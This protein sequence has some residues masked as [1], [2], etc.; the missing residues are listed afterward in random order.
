[1][2]HTYIFTFILSLTCLNL[3]AQVTDFITGL[4]TP[5]GMALNGN[6]LYVAAP[7]ANKI[8]KID[9]TATTPTATDVVT[10]LS[11]PRQLF[12]S[13]NDLYI[14]EHGASKISK[15]NITDAPLVVTDVINGLSNP[16]GVLVN[17][18]DLYI[19]EAGGEKVSKFNLAAASPTT[20][21]FITG[22]QYPT[23]FA[24]NGN[25][26]YVGDSVENNI[27]KIDLT[28]TTPTATEVVAASGPF[29]LVLYENEIYILEN[30]S[31]RVSKIDFTSATPTRT[32]VVTGLE[33]YPAGM[34][35]K[36]DIIYI[37]EIELGK[38]VSTQL[39]LSTNE[40]PF[41]ENIRLFP[42]PSSESIQLSGLT[43]EESYTIF[44]TQ[45][46]VMQSG[47]VSNQEHIGIKTLSKGLYFLK[48]DSGRAFRF[49]R[50]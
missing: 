12:F 14:T 35:I 22:L 19:V 28:A 41:A 44:N 49:V 11:A 7:D 38:I 4:T 26:L 45:G 42:N 1:M 27:I 8:I 10:G 39:P 25:D 17:G 24:L 13:G 34:V 15:I 40:N 20:T 6:D 16:Q 33:D 2:K 36:D 5:Q 9:L 23:G 47:V 43:T 21:D 31:K 37:S 46:A 50:E 3:M 18:D 29:S 30:P 48:L 32:V